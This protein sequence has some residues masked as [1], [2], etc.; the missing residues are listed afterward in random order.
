[1][2]HS[3]GTGVFGASLMSPDSWGGYPTAVNWRMP[4]YD[5]TNS[6]HFR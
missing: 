3:V 2:A 5:Y 4:H 1:M 6:I